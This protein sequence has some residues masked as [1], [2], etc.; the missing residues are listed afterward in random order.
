MRYDYKLFAVYQ[1]N[2]TRIDGETGEEKLPLVNLPAVTGGVS[3]TA[4]TIAGG[5][6]QGVANDNVVIG[7]YV[8]GVSGQTGTK[9]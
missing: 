3:V 2:Q 5:N 7:K 6:N 8:S 4:V 9:M 1:Q